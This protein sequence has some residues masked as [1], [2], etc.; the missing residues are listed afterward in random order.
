V[1]NVDS[2]VKGILLLSRL[3]FLREHGGSSFEQVLA[4]LAPADSAVLRGAVVPEAWYP[5]GLQLRL[6][7]AI[8][9]L[10]SADVRSDVFVH[11]GRASADAMLASREWSHLISGAPHS[12]LEA[13]PRLYGTH[14]SAGTREYERVDANGGII[15]TSG[16]EH[17]VTAEDCWTVVGWLQRVLELCGAKGVLVAEESCRATGAPR[18]EYHCEW[19]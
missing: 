3:E 9:S 2:Q 4:R 16:A 10:V 18:C 15:R 11:L 8:A 13:V 7:D 17:L 1:S 14:Y 5:L 19:C 12:V 6:D